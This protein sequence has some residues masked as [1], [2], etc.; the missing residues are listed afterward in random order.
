M[1]KDGNLFPCEV[2][3]IHGKEI[4]RLSQFSAQKRR[5][6]TIAMELRS[7]PSCIKR[8]LHYQSPSPRRGRG[9]REGELPP[10]TLSWREGKVLFLLKRVVKTD[11]I[12]LISTSYLSSEGGGEERGLFNGGRPPLGEGV[13]REAEKDESRFSFRMGKDGNLFPCEVTFIHGKEVVRLSQF[14]AQK[15]RW[16][17]IVM[18]VFRYR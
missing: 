6:E 13:D 7:L 4:V 1:G 2:T 5:W 18:E 17:T 11:C 16:E 12:N 10:H 3:F 9:D 8:N 14:S 15:R